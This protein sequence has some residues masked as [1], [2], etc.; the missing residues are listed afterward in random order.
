MK[1]IL[2]VSQKELVEKPVFKQDKNLNYMF[3]ILSVENSVDLLYLHKNVVV[4]SEKNDNNEDENIEQQYLNVKKV[5]IKDLMSKNMLQK[6]LKEFISANGY[7]QI[8]FMSYSLAQFIMPYIE[9]E[10]NK[11]VVVVDYRLSNISFLLKQYKEE[12]EK[13][14]QNF[15]GIYKQFRLNFLQS[16]NIF[17][18]GDY[19][20]FDKEEVDTY[21]LE[22]ENI[23]NIISVDD[24]RDNLVKKE[25][26][27][28]ENKI[29]EIEI[30][31][32]NFS[33]K[34]S[35]NVYKKSEY[36]YTV[37]ESK[38]FNLI[39]TINEII[40]N[41][42]VEYFFIYKKKLCILPGTAQLLSQCLSFNKNFA[43]ISPFSMYLRDST[44]DQQKYTFDV[45]RKGNFSNWEKT[46]PLKLADCFMIKKSFFYKYGHFDNKY[47]TIDYSLFDFLMRVYQKRDYY[48]TAKDI[49][50]F[51]TS[52]LTKRLDFFREDKQYLCNKWGENNFLF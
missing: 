5:C 32:D 20:I 37:Y 36:E 47:K 2:V 40:Q 15:Q 42:N 7:E 50:I 22:K 30:S 38:Y 39:N 6:N 34:I 26:N 28:K 17:N 3:N 25:R 8:I 51:K 29:V 44:Q 16:L 23:K 41:S 14:Y 27:V 19:F 45:Q 11:M 48:C 52:N 31:S 49:V 4:S 13:E 33:A 9:E 24:I 35:S 1:K 21:L 43:V 46:A 12:N 18:K 10:L